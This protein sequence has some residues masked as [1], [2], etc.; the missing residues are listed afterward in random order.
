MEFCISSK[1]LKELYLSGNQLT[2]LPPEIGNL[3]NL[4]TLSL[5]M[6]QL[7]SLPLEIGKL[8]NLQTL[9]LSENQF[10]EEEKEKLKKLLPNCNIYF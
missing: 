4:K 9:Y 1:N 6:N 2:I 5:D 10:S 3:T 8:V 7:T